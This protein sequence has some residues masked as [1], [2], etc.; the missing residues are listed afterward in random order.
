MRRASRS[1][2]TISPPLSARGPGLK[3]STEHPA[4]AK[5]DLIVPEAVVLVAALSD[6]I[7]QPEGWS[8]G[9]PAGDRAVLQPVFVLDGS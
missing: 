3:P 4:P 7:G 9:L 2:K 6:R 8:P 1:P 5:L